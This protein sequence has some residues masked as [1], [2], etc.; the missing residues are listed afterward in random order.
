MIEPLLAS[1]LKEGLDLLMV[2]VI[3]VPL[4]DVVARLYMGSPRPVLYLDTDSSPD[5]Q[6]RAMEDAVRI[7]AFGFG[8][9]RSGRRVRHLRSVS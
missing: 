3:E 8:A 5:E 2:D 6:Y 7:L 4:P 1:A 9:A